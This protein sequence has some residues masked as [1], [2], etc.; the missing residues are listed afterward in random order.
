ML[1]RL[2]LRGVTGDLR[3]ILPRPEVDGDGPVAAVREIIDAVR[4]GGDAALRELTQ[5]F[6]GCDLPTAR[7]DPAALAAALGSID[8]DLRNALVVAHDNIRRYHETQRDE[9]RHFRNN[10]MTI[11]GWMA[12][13]ERAGLYVPGG[14]AIY[15]STVLM[16]AV[17]ARVAGVREIV[18]CVPPAADGSVP[19]TTLAAAAIAGV[20]EVYAVGGAQAIAAMAYGTDTIAPVDVIVGPGNV[21]VALAKR[22][23]AGVV[24]V[25]S[26]FAGPSEVVVIADETTDP[27]LAAID[28]VVQAE[29]GPHGLAW[30]ITTSVAVA[31]AID[32]AIGRAVA[33]APRRADIEATLRDGGYVVVVE[34]LARAVD[35]ANAV[36]PEHL[37]L[38][39]AD[40][41]ALLPLVRHAGAIFCGPWSPAAMGDY[42][43]GPSHVLPTNSTARFSSV[44]SLRDFQKE[45]HAV[46]FDRPSFDALAPHVIALADAEGLDAHAQSIRL[47]VAGAR[48]QRATSAPVRPGVRPDIALMEG[49]HSP[50]LAVDVRLNTN[51][52][53]E[54]PP[55]EFTALLADE[56]TRVEWHRYP[57]RAARELR[58]ALAK[59]YGVA[60]EQVFAANGSN[61]VLLNMLLAY[62]GPGRRAAVFEPTYALHSHIA[63]LAGTEVVEGERGHDFALDLDEVR[64]VIGTYRPEIVFLCSPN[65]P[66]AMV[67]PP[68]VVQTVLD[69]VAPYGGMVIVDEAYGQFAP[70]SA[71]SMV[72]DDVP[73]VVTR[74]FSKTWSMAAARLGYLIGPSWVV[75][76]LDK[77]A[78]P[79]H[80]DVV[81]QI[82]GTLALRFDAQMQARVASLVEERGRLETAL[83]DLPVEVWPSGA[84]F[85]L[86]RPTAKDG[87]A[88]WNALLDHSVLV[89]DC[90]SWPRL[91]GCLRVTIG[92]RQE[93]DRFL[94]ALKE[95]LT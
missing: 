44:L 86:F 20:D 13:V 37:Q 82:A 73:L 53:P 28:V 65:N 11:D 80:L 48:D 64:R 6:D 72:A 24:G 69:L 63:R 32:A 87:A 2:D 68:E 19:P 54:P 22:E 5:R 15:P 49:Y 91:D 23:V 27:D 34:S 89:R 70:S 79:Y 31:D 92:S 75:D 16:T 17:P 83:R 60:T 25:P 88:V 56:I 35:V 50:Q 14:R 10:G 57:D 85:I 67:D 47:R 51:E 40:P 61:E 12:P 7:V 38:M 43:A 39:C 77:V 81:K 55:A 62:G 30:L 1:N 71:V 94:A 90:S 33:A 58:G 3:R 26:A 76:E 93:D 74:T 59:H 46:T 78:L 95:I 21:Y 42:A 52:S 84:N 18:L 9:P 4:A 36:A 66:T 8:D 41:V 45:M 29:H